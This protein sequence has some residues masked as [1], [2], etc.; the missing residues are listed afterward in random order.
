MGL[1]EL[2]LLDPETGKTEV[3]QSD[4]LKRGRFHGAIFSATTDDLAFT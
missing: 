3:E 1:A 2:V 4:P